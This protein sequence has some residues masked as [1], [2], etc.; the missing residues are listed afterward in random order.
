[1][2]TWKHHMPSD[3]SGEH[4]PRGWST[5]PAEIALASASPCSHDCCWHSRKNATQMPAI[6]ASLQP[7]GRARGPPLRSPRT[8]PPAQT[9]QR[10]VSAAQ[11]QSRVVIDSSHGRHD[12]TGPGP[13]LCAPEGIAGSA[14]GSDVNVTSSSVASIEKVSVTDSTSTPSQALSAT[15][16]RRSRSQRSVTSSSGSFH[17][18]RCPPGWMPAVVI[19][20]RRNQ[21]I[22]KTSYEDTT[23]DHDEQTPN[24]DSRMQ[25][26]QVRKSVP[27]HGS[28]SLACDSGVQVREAVATA[29]SV[30]LDARDD[31]RVRRLPPRQLGD[32]R[33]IL[34][35]L[36]EVIR[37]HPA[38][39]AL[40]VEQPPAPRVLVQREEARPV[41]RQLA[42]GA[43]NPAPPAAILSET[44]APLASGGAQA[45]RRGASFAARSVGMC[46]PQQERPSGG[47]PSR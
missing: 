39:V 45:V 11:Q 9:T 46:S 19:T 3:G 22:S 10:P 25:L 1:M 6:V 17:S 12:S 20:C 35:Q 32:Q 30:R 41:L 8:A 15:Q 27:H 43:C 21:T 23:T 40:V 2:I 4:S 33:Q 18:Q 26:W 13:G 5:K 16:P 28:K 31:R 37:Q 7:P 44:S 42:V 47:Q 38:V 36:R 29:H 14:A 34:R 24:T